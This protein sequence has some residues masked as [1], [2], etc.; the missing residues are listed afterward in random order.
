MFGAPARA[1]ILVDQ[2]EEVFT[3]CSYESQRH[4]FI[5]LLY[6]LSS[7]PAYVSSAVYA[8]P[9]A[10]VLISVRADSYASC[11]RYQSLLSSL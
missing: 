8:E 7:R 5:Y 9:A 2:F 10:L 11:F 4:A 6:R 1:V 3:L